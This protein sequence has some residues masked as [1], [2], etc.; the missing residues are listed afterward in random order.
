MRFRLFGLFLGLAVAIASWA[1][2]CAAWRFDRVAEGVL[3]LAPREF[4]RLT[5]VTL[6]TGGAYEN[7]ARRGPATAVALGREVW[8]VD[9]GRGVAEGLRAGK[10][11]VSQP[12]GVLLT[13]LLPENTVGLDDLLLTGWRDGRAAPLRV[14]GPPG[15]RALLAGIAAGHAQGLAALGAALGL[16]PAG[17][18]WEATEIAGG[19]SEARGELVLRAAALPG[20]PLGA[21]AYRFEVGGRSIVVS[22]TGWAPEALVDFARGASILVHEAAF[23]PTPE[24]AGE[25]GIDEAQAGRLA[26]EAR[27]HTALADVG[28]IAARAGVASL[29]LVRLRPP[30]VYDLQITMLVDDSYSGRIVIAEDGDEITP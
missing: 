19:W 24:I 9:A 7:P 22:A 16:P 17:A 1:L 25:L 21:L 12:A 13:N 2:T 26:R 3:P 14:V 20:G 23:V 11:P 27:L 6:G 8:L 4:P 30:P 18:A 5:L 10:L 28:G 15:T 29:V